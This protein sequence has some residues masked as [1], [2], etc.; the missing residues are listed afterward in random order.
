[1]EGVIPY[2]II[3][4]RCTT[5]GHAFFLYVGVTSR[6]SLTANPKVCKLLA[7]YLS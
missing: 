2:D 7:P 4:V 6:L 1:M 3:A 5:V